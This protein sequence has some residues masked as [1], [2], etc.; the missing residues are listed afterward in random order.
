[1]Y[2]KLAL[3]LAMSGALA[4]CATPRQQCLDTA[5]R[6]LVVVD[7]LIAETRGN[8]ERGYG[9]EREQQLR[10]TRRFCTRHVRDDKGRLRPISGF[11]PETRSVT[12]ERPVAID[13]GAERRKLDQLM[14]KRNQLQDRTRAQVASCQA[15]YPAG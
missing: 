13:L 15:R 3:M 10:T 1:M 8:L 7:S 14:E 5:Q 4:A 9:L 6:D 12:R 11:C 2:A